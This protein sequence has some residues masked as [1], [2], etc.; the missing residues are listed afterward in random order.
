MQDGDGVAARVAAG[1]ADGGDLFEDRLGDAGLL[2][3]LTMGGGVEVLIL[4][5]EAARQRPGAAEGRLAAL[6]QQHAQP[7]V[8]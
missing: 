6:N 5:D 4:A 1:G 3:Q 8:L 2:L 7:Q